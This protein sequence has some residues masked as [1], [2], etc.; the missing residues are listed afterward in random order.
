MKNLIKLLKEA[1][2]PISYPYYQIIKLTH[3]DRIIYSYSDKINLNNWL[4]S[5]LNL[6]KQDVE[7]KKMTDDT[8]NSAYMGLNPNI[9]EWKIEV[10]ESN[11]PTPEQA[12]NKARELQEKEGGYVSTR[13][14][15]GKEHNKGDKIEVKRED[16]LNY[17]NFTFI[18][19]TAWATNKTYKNH[20][21]VDPKKQIKVQ[22]KYYILVKS[23]NIHEI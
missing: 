16:L 2:A 14:G 5:L 1:S 7:H 6:R 20:I 11:I 4:K 19:Q 3:N 17:N 8:S 15:R 13:G 18:N 23:K 12:K 10:V 9:D 21:K 22:N